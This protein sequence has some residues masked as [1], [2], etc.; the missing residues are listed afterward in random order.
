MLRSHKIKVWEKYLQHIIYLNI[1]SSFK[2]ARKITNIKT[3]EVHEETMQ[4]HTHPKHPINIFLI[5]V[6][7]EMQIKIK[8]I[9]LLSYQFGKTA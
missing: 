1:E 7:R 5:T 2:L 4:T 8:Q 9:Q 3:D 6:I